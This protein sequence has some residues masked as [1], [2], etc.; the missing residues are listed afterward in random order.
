MVAQSLVPAQSARGFEEFVTLF[1]TAT[2]K[3]LADV[4]GKP[5]LNEAVRTLFK[6]RNGLAHGRSVEYDTFANYETRDFDHDF[7]GSYKE[8]EDYLIKTKL[9]K[10]RFAEGSSGWDFFTDAVADH[11]INLIDMYP[12]AVVRRLPRKAA[13][14]IRGLLALSS[15]PRHW[16]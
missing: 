6:F 16:C 1:K 13:A 8:V 9:L 4:V 15:K 14:Y 11:F 5:E 7:V 2:G 10:M 12:K 3:S